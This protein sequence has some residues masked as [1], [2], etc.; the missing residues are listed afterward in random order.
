MTRIMYDSTSVA[1]IPLTTDLAAA[2]GNGVFA[3]VAGLNARFPDRSKHVLI[4]VNGSDAL[5]CDVLDVEYGNATPA[6]ARPWIQQRLAAGRRATVYCNRDTIPAVWAA[7]AGL[8]Y[9]LW[10]ATLDGTTTWNGRELSSV[11]GVVAVQYQGQAQTG[12]HADKSLVYD[13]SWPAVRQPPQPPKPVQALG[14]VVTQNL[15]V[16]HVKSADG[17]TW[18]AS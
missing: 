8:S 9:N 15:G 3:D 14:I 1:D 17:K 10:I 12:I 5:F 4:D 18:V 13:D 7:C 2:Y 11:A 6:Q 16:L